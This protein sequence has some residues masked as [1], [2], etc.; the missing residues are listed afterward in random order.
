MKSFRVLDSSSP[1]DRAEWL[2]IWEQ[3]PSRLP[4][5][6]PGVAELL[7][8]GTG[9]LL[10]AVR[11]TEGSTV[12]YPYVLRQIG[13]GPLH[14][15]V[16]PYGYG[17]PLHWGVHDAGITAVPFWQAFE[18]WAEANDVVAEFIRFALV[19]ELLPYPGA[20]R[21]RNL[22]YVARLPEDPEELWPAVH[23]KVRQAVRRAQRSGL[24]HCVD[25]EG[26]LLEDF[27]RVYTATMERNDSDEWYKFSES[28][29]TRLHQEMGDRMVIVAAL[30]AGRVVSANLM[31]AGQGSVYAFLGGTYEDAFH[32]RPVDFVDYYSMEWAC[33]EGFRHY[34]LGGGMSPGDGLEKYKARFATTGGVVFQTGERVFDEE[35]FDSLV[36]QRQQQ[37]AD[38]SLPWD[39]HVDF[40]PPYRRPLPL[41]QL[42]DSAL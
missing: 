13:D 19:D 4:Y 37:F 35:A 29:F 23:K 5:A 28:F 30:D 32:M 14:D 10:A 11:D 36:A 16:S 9:R 17:G 34:V 18:Q 2:E 31:L 20:T 12:L 25:R 22:N 27:V 7:T 42:A 3:S 26:A 8:E 1:A 33:E 38:E 39:E 40:F 6:H 15:I 24:T 21:A 41:Q